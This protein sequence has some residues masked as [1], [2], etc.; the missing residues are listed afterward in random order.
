M[1]T[2]DFEVLASEDG[3]LGMIWLRERELP[4]DPGTVI[5]EIM[6]NHELLMSSYHTTS[7]RAL[8]SCSLERHPGS[9]LRVLIGGLGLGYTAFEALQSERVEHVEVVELLPPVAEWLRSGRVPLSA[10]LNEDERFTVTTG[11]IFGQLAAAPERRYDLILIDVDH[12]PDERLGDTNAG[13][14]TPAG[15]ELAK[16][17]L[18]EGGVLGVWSYAEN[19]PFADAL[20]KVFAHVDLEAVSFDNVLTEV[21]EN[22]WLFIAND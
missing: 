16:A 12:A 13:F 4:S 7:E 8:A 1:S 2:L 22:N 11:D 18:A 19:S 5:T 6:I 14:Y 20:R 21:H 3:P 9:A 15:L 10:D 17:H